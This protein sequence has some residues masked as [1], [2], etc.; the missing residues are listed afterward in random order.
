MRICDICQANGVQRIAVGEIPE[1]DMCNVHQKQLN[2]VRA[3]ALNLM[4]TLKPGEVLE[5]GRCAEIAEFFRPVKP[6]P[7]KMD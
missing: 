3:Y 4:R 2:A 1:G 7:T 5:E 6:T